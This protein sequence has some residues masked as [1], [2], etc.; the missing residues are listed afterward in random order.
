MAR[1]AQTRRRP[2]PPPPR[3]RSSGGGFPLWTTVALV[4]LV[5]GIVVVLLAI[6]RRDDG[7]STGSG[8]LIEETAEPVTVTG[9]ALP[10]FDPTVADPAVGTPFPRFAGT[11][12]DGEPLDITPGDEPLVLVFLAHWCPHCQ[13]EVPRIQDWVED[14]NP[15][16]DVGFYGVSTGID[17]GRP[18]YPSSDWFE[19]EGWTVPTLVD[20]DNAAGTA[21]GLTAFPYYVVVDG[22]GNV[23]SR[24]SGEI[25]TEQLTQLVELARG[26]PTT[27]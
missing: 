16:D 9:A 14:G 19:R 20:V 12:L 25:S 1:A 21:A 7:P 15:P 6:V 22:N 23:V 2:P 26:Q 24:V 27:P 11:G 17:E 5:I 4:V 10:P 3:R 18:N 8:G 13:A